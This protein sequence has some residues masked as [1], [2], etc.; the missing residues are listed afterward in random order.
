MISLGGRTIEIISTDAEGR[1]ILADALDYARQQN[2]GRIIDIAT[3]TGACVVALGTVCTGVFGNNQELIDRV[4]SA[5]VESGEKMWQL[6]VYEE[7]KEQ[8]K[9]DVA[10]IKNTG[11]RNA[12]AIT[13]ALFVGEF[14]GDTPWVHLDIAGTN[15][16]DK[17]RRYEV[18]GATG[19]PVRTL[20][21]VVL[22]LAEK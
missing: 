16:I 13:A 15:M 3:L 8:N 22:G 11:G 12:G 5:G 17:A 14:A 21:N 18:K 6:P 4:I 10:D 19:V 9:S 1:L 20:V 7:Y 2:A